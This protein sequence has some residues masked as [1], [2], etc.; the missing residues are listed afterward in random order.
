VSLE[1]ALVDLGRSLDV[2]EPVDLLPT[3]VARL[4]R[5]PRR[6]PERRRLAAA[7]GLAALVALVA[8][9]VVP[10]ARSA[11]LRLL[12]IGGERVVLVDELP[13]VEPLPRGFDLVLGEEVTLAEARART[14]LELARLEGSPDPDRV[15]L[16]PRETVWFLWGTPRRVRLLLAQTREL[17]PGTPPLVEKQVEAGGEVEP[18]SVDGAR[19]IFLGGSRHVVLLLDAAGEPV[20]EAVWLARDVLVWERAGT[21]FRLEGELSRDRA[22][23]LARAVR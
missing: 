8:T 4:E 9:L 11:L 7:V 21:T 23:E 19:G 5:P 15:Y 1:R 20:E 10:D 6:R 17:A 3:V 22:L 18:V 16:G 14:G 12:S 13:E 2:P